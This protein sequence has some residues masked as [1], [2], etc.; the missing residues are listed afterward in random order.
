VQHPGGALLIDPYLSDSLASKYAGTR[1]PHRRLH[2]VPV[3]PERLHG[4]DLVLH[5]HAHTD[6]LDPLTVAALLTNNAPRFA[7]PRARREV[8]LSRGIPPDLLVSV[9][10]GDAFVL[11]GAEVQVVPAAHE[12]LTV[13]DAGNHVFV[14]Y[15]VEVAGVRVYHSGDCAPYPGQAELL[16][17][18]DIDV[19]LLPVNG[20]DPERLANGVPGNFTLQEAVRLCHEADIPELVCHHIGLFDFNTVPP[21][22]LRGQLRAAA[23]GRAWTIPAVGAGFEVH[24][25]AEEVA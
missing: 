20:R 10:A 24:A 13:D 4:V 15:V 19:A 9:T 3:P 6:H 21:A 23:G 11:A 22:D 16:A 25:S 2:P 7:S 1:Y 12:E 8:A 14:G 18:L 17:S 5:T